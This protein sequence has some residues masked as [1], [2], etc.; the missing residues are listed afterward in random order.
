MKRLRLPA[1]GALAALL[2]AALCYGLLSRPAERVDYEPVG[3]PPRIRPDYADAV[4]PP[5]IAPLTFC[6]EE[7]GRKY[8][9]R[10]YSDQQTVVSVRSRTPA[11]VMPRRAWRRLLKRA[12]GRN[13]FFEVHVQAADGRWRRFEPIAVAVAREEIDP[14]MVY[15][16]MN[17]I[18]RLWVHMEIRQRNLENY[19]DSVVLDN[20]LLGNSCVN[21][22]TFLQNRPDRMTIQIRRGQQDYGSGMVMVDGGVVTKVD[23]RTQL[24]SRPAVYVSWHPDGT[25]LAFSTNKVRQFF[26]S[27]RCEVRDVVDLESDLAL[28]VLGSNSVT[29]TGSI[30]RPDRLE[31]WPTWSPDGR[32]LYFCS[33]PLPW[34]LD[35]G[36][37]PV[38]RADQVRY[39]LM[40]IGYDA[41]AGRW[42]EL[43]TVL[44]AEQI[45]LSISQ[46]RISPDGRFLLFC[47]SQYGCFPIF[48]S[49]ADLYML[50]V[51]AGRHWRLAI[52]S[53]R[54]DSWHSWSGNGRWFVFSSKRRDDL[55]AKPYFAYVE[56]NGTVRKPFLLPQAD[57][58][59]YDCLLKTYNVPE[60]VR[61]PVP[62][63]G[64]TVARVIRSEP[65]VQAD[66]Q[67]TSATPPA[68]SALAR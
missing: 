52:N 31:T 38:E 36:E 44:S 66:F 34:P 35:A 56:E 62:V 28:Y 5:N 24:I 19:D 20:G 39:D 30:A 4:I 61:A 57:P 68:G 63:S 67:V 13:L 26:H 60:L 6:V 21:C 47:A 29:S 22:H 48:Q 58:T 32:Y 33:A 10:A 16:F 25:L 3:R 43:E 50:D 53:D 11:I 1:V 42:G 17:P 55:L 8:W 40:R 49:S 45:G 65:W 54:C 51:K 9:V 2:I 12:R 18:H 23:T 7:P 64:Q 14:Y 15:R 59:F 37:M 41:S 27:A 46:P